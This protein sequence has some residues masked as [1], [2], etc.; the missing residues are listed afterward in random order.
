MTKM[1]D[2]ETGKS[3]QSQRERQLQEWVDAELER[4]LKESA[5]HAPLKIASDDAS[6]R[7]YFRA[8]VNGSTYIAVDAPPEH[9]DSEQ[10]VKVAELLQ[11]A[12]V[13]VP[14]VFSFDFESGFMLLEDFG[15]G[16]YLPALLDIKNANDVETADRIYKQVVDAL[17]LIQSYSL[18]GQLDP[19][20][21]AELRREM[22]LFEEW[23]CTGL[24]KMEISDDEHTLIAGALRFL[25]DSALSQAT[26]LVHR[27][28]HSRNLMLLGQDI[29]P[30]IIDFQDAVIGPYT[31]DLVSLLRD[32]YISW[33]PDL[34][35]KWA[36]YYLHQ[37]RIS[38]VGVPADAAQFT[39]D[40]DLMGLQR[41]LKVLGVF[42]RLAIRDNKTRYLAD[43]PLV[44]HYFME[45][46][47]GYPEL[48]AFREWFQATVLP[49]AKKRIPTN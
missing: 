16:T 1:V 33:S 48:G 15:D 46:S 8:T 26:V 22:D 41:H 20:D 23:F 7:R 17:V 37:A 12:G 47:S 39:R 19:Y 3:S 28:F 49:L 6:F 44:I 18:K 36:D 24:L 32:C 4:L 35:T 43:I 11:K 30:G 31:Y 14:K 5:L 29:G 21:R 40:L 27:D 45:I 2:S 42:A 38:G 10:F 25:E 13:R 9:E 34:V